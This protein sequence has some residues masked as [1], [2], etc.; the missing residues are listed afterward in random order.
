MLRC[1][2]ESSV[3]AE[4][5]PSPSFPKQLTPQAAWEG[6]PAACLP[7]ALPRG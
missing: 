4:P 7:S 2:G 3:A 6:N 5:R 1:S